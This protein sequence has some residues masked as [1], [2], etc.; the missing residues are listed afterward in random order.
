MFFINK[1]QK[2][3][4]F[5]KSVFLIKYFYCN[6]LIYKLYV[7]QLFIL[8]LQFKYINDIEYDKTSLYNS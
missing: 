6:I 4:F 2:S 7:I 1:K 5:T 3:V 8:K